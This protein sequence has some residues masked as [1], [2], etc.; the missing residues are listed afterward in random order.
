MAVLVSSLQEGIDSFEKIWRCLSRCILGICKK[1]AVNI[2]NNIKATIK[3]IHD[4][5]QQSLKRKIIKAAKPIKIKNIG[6][7]MNILNIPGI[8]K[9]IRLLLD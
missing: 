6:S 8:I 7:I 4:R 5:L 2:N 9:N 1:E 3:A